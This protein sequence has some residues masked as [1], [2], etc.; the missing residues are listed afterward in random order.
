M[1]LTEDAKQKILALRAKGYSYARIGKEL[2]FSPTSVRK[3]VV[4]AVKGGWGGGGTALPR[5][6][7]AP[8]TPGAAVL[9]E[10]EQVQAKQALDE[11]KGEL[12]S[13]T[14]ADLEAL[15]EAAEDVTKEA[16][17]DKNWE[18]LTGKCQERL[19]WVMEKVEAV[20]TPEEA[21]QIASILDGLEAEMRSA[22]APYTTR[23]E[24][25]RR[26]RQRLEVD[27]STKLL[28]KYA[29]LPG[30]PRPVVRAV[31]EHLLAM[32]E[33]QAEKVQHALL[34][35]RDSFPYTGDEPTRRRLW[36]PFLQK[37]KA[38]R[39]AYI[40]TLD[41]EYKERQADAQRFAFGEWLVCPHCY[42]R[43]RVAMGSIGWFEC[44][45]CGS[46]VWKGG[47]GPPALPPGY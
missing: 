47:P 16:I 24:E 12:W 9:Q 32:D 18:K 6:T 40:S 36:K 22:M 7:G 23:V 26:H 45:R 28:T 25:A 42:Y 1:A 5:S 35:Y 4:E 27:R 2:G 20:S 33:A 8:A 31:K 3:V 41:Q 14:E 17:G 38:E 13:R 11:R 30:V 46:P 19:E 29:R 34:E 10:Y 21:D 15:L 44:P 37:L 43:L 39:W